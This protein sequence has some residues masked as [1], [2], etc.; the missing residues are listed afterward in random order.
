MFVF[1][2]FAYVFVSV[3]RSILTFCKHHT[4]PVLSFRVGSFP[5]DVGAA[6]AMDGKHQ[7]RTGGTGL[8]KSP[9]LVDPNAG[10]TTSC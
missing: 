5:G 4:S 2:S 7:K 1:Y 10:V 8:L 9:R 6:K 3:W